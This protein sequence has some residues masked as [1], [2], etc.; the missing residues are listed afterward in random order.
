M[1]IRLIKGGRPTGEEIE[2]NCRGCQCHEADIQ[3][4]E[5]ADGCCRECGCPKTVEAFRRLQ[6]Q[7]K[8]SIG[9]E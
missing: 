4:G 5:L 6:S 7:Q 2:T 3:F 9:A 1:M 8:A